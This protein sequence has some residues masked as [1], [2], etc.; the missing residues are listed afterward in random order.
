MLQIA[1]G[2]TLYFSAQDGSNSMELWAHRGAEF[3]PPP[4]NVN[5]ASS[6]SSSPSLPLGLSID[7]STCTISGTPMVETINRTYNVTAVI[8][9]ADLYLAVPMTNITFEFNDSSMF[10]LTNPTWTPSAIS[11]SANGPMGVYVAD[12]DGDGDLDIVTASKTD[13]SSNG[14]VTWWENGGSGT[15]T[16]N[17]IATAVDA[18]SVYVED[19]DGDGDLDVVAALFAQ[20]TI[21]LYLNSGASN[22]TWTASNIDTNAN[23]ATDVHVADMDGDGD[24]DVVSSSLEDDTIAWYKND[25]QAS[26]GWTSTNIDTNRQSARAVDVADM[27]GDG[28]LDIVTASS[29]DDTIAWYANGGQST[30][31]FTKTDI[32]STADAARDVRVADMDGDG[33]LDIV[34]GSY[35]DNTIAWYEQTGTG[36]W[37]NTTVLSQPAN[38]TCSISPSLPAGLSIDSSTC[39]I[40]GTPTV[41]TSN[42]TYTVTAVISNVTYQ[43]SVWLSPYATMT[44]AV[45]GAHLNLGE[46]M[47]PI[48]INYTQNAVI[49]S[50]A[51]VPSGAIYSNN[52]SSVGGNTVCAIDDNGDLKCWGSD[53]YGQLGTPGTAQ[54][55]TSPPS[56]PIDL[57]PGRTAVAVDTGGIGQTCAIL[58]N[59]DLKCWGNNDYGQLGDGTTTSR[60]SPSSTPVNLGA[61]RTAVAVSVGTY[62]TCAILDNGDLKCWGGDY[63]GQLG[64]GTT[65]VE[66]NYQTS[67]VLSPPSTPVDLG[68][69]RTAVAVDTNGVSTC[70]ILD[71][72]GL[73]CWGAGGNGMLGDGTTTSRNSPP[74]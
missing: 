33:D 52:K 37:T 22:P 57:G 68:T 18:R 45:E 29:G 6:C 11:T 16:A 1:V 9:G 39:T 42:T 50:G 59:G 70:A 41:E 5:G 55:L 65:T 23:G 46:A 49:S 31:S 12:V 69:G 25:G 67:R 35:M 56:T 15:W 21:K 48:T 36:T 20:D 17:D 44:S 63:H 8:S 72:G 14:K 62:H 28:D 66:G 24:L 73:K 71:N 4:A 30:P 26:P 13:S 3:T 47:T 19:I 2:D 60:T 64:D 10:T 51:I 40:S 38:A 27:D 7:S 58:D 32:S 53:Q 74:S 43:G 61:G 54:L 34:S